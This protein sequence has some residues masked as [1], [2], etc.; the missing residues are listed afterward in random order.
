MAHGRVFAGASRFAPKAPEGHRGGL[1]RL[2]AGSEQWERLERGLPA[3]V[4]VR[5]VLV[6]PADSSVVW[7]GT[8]DG[9]YRSVD[10]GDTWAR[11]DFPVS[12]VAIWSLAIHPTHHRTLY[13]GGS[14]ATVYRS[15]DG[16]D[17][18]HHL[19]HA[20]LKN[21]VEMGFPTRLVS[22]AID[23]DKPDTVWAGVEVGGVIR[24]DDG[25]ETWIDCSAPLEAMGQQPEL[26]NRLASDTDSEGMLDTH[27]LVVT[28]AA[29]GV[30]FLAVR[31][32]IFRTG[33]GGTNW[34]SLDV[35]RSSPL[36]YCRD[37]KVSPHDSAVLY[38]TL[39]DEAQGKVGTLYRSDDVG[40]TW[41]RYDNFAA[42]STLMKV[43]PSPYSPEEV[44]CATRQGDVYG[45][46]DGGKT[47]LELPLPT[48][49]RDVYSLECG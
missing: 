28:T 45:T 17:T 14:P 35:G 20:W 32:G 18:W 44:W 36:T 19:R 2:A 21:R 34:Q 4:Q 26:R 25:G 13:A 29:P 1:F 7:V 3:D 42:T 23:N 10:G 46:V 16:G 39:S 9:P 37:V 22:L 15:T 48:G 40:A 12:G 6:H 49:G 43:A 41:V 11:P 5:A 38:A 27:A 47:W 24:S 33:D 30:A 31:M 8:Q